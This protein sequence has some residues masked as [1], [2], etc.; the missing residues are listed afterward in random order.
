MIRGLIASLLIA[1][2]CLPA[3]AQVEHP[4]VIV[5]SYYD[6]NLAFENATTSGYGCTVEAVLGPDWG[7]A[8]EY[9]DF[10]VMQRLAEGSGRSGI[11][12]RVVT[13]AILLNLHPSLE[14]RF[15]VVAAIGIGLMDVSFIHEP[16][17][18]GIFDEDQR[19]VMIQAKLGFRLKLLDGVHI[20]AHASVH[21][22]AS[23]G[24][25]VTI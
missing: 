5:S 6:F 25:M 8:L 10:R 1:I 13:P 12:A 17:P 24:L 23:A 16:F 21:H 20:F 22:L 19:L 7:V 11:G 15:A 3:E 2:F 4:A 18:F 14:G 9:S